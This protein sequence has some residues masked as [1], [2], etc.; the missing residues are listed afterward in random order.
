MKTAG[1]RKLLTWAMGILHE[2]PLPLKSHSTCK[3][4]H[5]PDGGRPRGRE[6]G[7]VLV[8]T[9]VGLTAFMGIV[10]LVADG[11][12]LWTAKRQMETAAD[13][14]AIA[15]A[16][17]LWQNPGNNTLATNNADNVSSLNGFTNSAAVGGTN[18]T[19]NIPP[20]SGNYAGQSG[21]VEVIIQQPR[22]VYFMRLFGRSSVTVAARAVAGEGNSSNCIF[23]LDPNDDAAALNVNGSAGVT[24][25]CGA[26]VNSTSDEAAEC[27][28]SAGVTF[29]ALGVVGP[30]TAAGDYDH[31]C[32]GLSPAQPVANIIP[33]SDPLE[34][35][36]SSTPTLG[37]SS[38]TC[39]KSGTTTISGLA[40]GN[41]TI[42][43]GIYCGAITVSSNAGTTVAIDA[44]I[45]QSGGVVISGNSGGN[46]TLGD[47]S[48]TPT[49]CIYYGGVYISGD[50]GGVTVYPGT[51][52]GGIT[53]PGSA[54]I[55]FEPG[56]YIVAGAGG[57]NSSGNAFNVAGG[58]GITGTGVTFYD[59]VGASPYNTYAPIYVVGS[60]ATS[61]S[62]PTS[63]TYAG[64]LFYQTTN[65]PVGSAASTVEGSAGSTL[66]GAL[67]FPTTNL[68]F[69]GSSG[70]DGYG[71]IVAYKLTIAGS[72]GTY[73]GVTYPSGESPIQTIGLYE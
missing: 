73:L 7:Q 23:V 5:C 49:T 39:T 9:A 37:T 62:A 6:R 42:S 27:N 20:L 69:D 30:E 13:A 46:I 11:G 55:T 16:T 48:C 8:F 4:M 34:R 72:A 21:F 66:D 67:Y 41:Q 15:G 40:G 52:Y 59:T 70:S 54:S 61:V 18:I 29:A 50:S 32:S 53:V 60:A 44:R 25:L 14:A 17:A 57:Q 2:S 43:P 45:V 1:T 71:I 31:G 33:A 24:T 56:L 47:S 63:G 64:I 19:V 38:G 58:A 36:D 28:G 26:V 3:G 22:P 65:I 68:T 12:L 51:Y 10:G 35:L